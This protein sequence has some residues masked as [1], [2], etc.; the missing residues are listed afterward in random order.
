MQILY[1]VLV[2]IITILKQLDKLSYAQ[3]IDFAIIV[4]MGAIWLLLPS[5]G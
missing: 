5:D 4:I 1:T 3:L 2:I